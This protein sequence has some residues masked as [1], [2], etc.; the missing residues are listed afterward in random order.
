MAHLRGKDLQAY[1][2]KEAAK[3]HAGSGYGLK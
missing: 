2:A 1:G 3:L